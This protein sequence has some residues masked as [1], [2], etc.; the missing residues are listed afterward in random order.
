VTES[1]PGDLTDTVGSQHI[2]LDVVTVLVPR[3]SLGEFLAISLAKP[4][5]C[6][7]A[8][9]GLYVDAVLPAQLEDDLDGTD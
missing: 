5:G 9:I 2:P 3:C 7:T 6:H 1:D 8:L 4:E